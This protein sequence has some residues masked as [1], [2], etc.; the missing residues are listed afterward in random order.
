M[1]RPQSLCNHHLFLDLVGPDSTVLDLGAYEGEFAREISQ[2]T[3]AQVV[4]V[5]A[6]P[7][8]YEKMYTSERVTGLNLA[9]GDCEGRLRLFVGSNPLGSSVYSTHPYSDSDTIEVSATTLARLISDHCGGHVDLLKINIEGAEIPMLAAAADEVLQGISQIT[10]QFH[11]FIP[12]LN[13][14]ADVREAKARLQG[15]GFGEILF[16]SPNKDVLFV[17]LRTGVLGRGRFG[18]EKVLVR[19]RQYLRAVQKKLG[20]TRGLAS[21]GPRRVSGGGSM[22]LAQARHAASDRIGV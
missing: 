2:R 8:M 1:S 6:N 19:L 20:Q 10:I 15:L 12:E 13:Q 17:N 7:F 5:E 14:A 21:T 4:A 18:A 9:V 16:K 11:D 22:S 3:Q